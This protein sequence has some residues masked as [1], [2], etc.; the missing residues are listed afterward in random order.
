MIVHDVCYMVSEVLNLQP[1]APLS[2]SKSEEWPKWKRRFEQ[3]HQASGLVENDE[4]QQVSTL[5]YC[6][7][8]EAEEILDTTRISPQ[9]RVKYHKV[10]DEFDRYIKAKESVRANRLPR[11]KLPVIPQAPDKLPHDNYWGCG[12]D[13]QVQ[14]EIKFLNTVE[15]VDTV[16]N[17]GNSWVM[18]VAIG[19]K[20]TT[21]K[22]DT[23]AEVTVISEATGNSLDQSEPLQHPKVSLCGPDHSQLKVMGMLPLTIA[24]KEVYTTQPVYIVKN[25]K[26]NL[27]GFPAIKALKLLSHIESVDKNNLSEYPSLFSGLGTFTLEY[28]IQLKQDA[29]P[30]ALCTPRNIPLALRPKVQTELK[31]M[32]NLGVIS[33]V[34]EPTPWCAAMVVVPKASG[35]VRICVDVKPM[36][37]NV[38]REVHP[39]SKV[40]TTLAQLTGAAMFSKL[41]ANSGFWQIPL[42]EE[43]RLLTTFVTPY[44]RF[45]FNKL[46]FGI[47]SAPEVFQR[48]MNDIL[49]GLPGVLCHID[50]IL[51]FGTTPAEHDS[52]LQAV[53]ERI[54]SAGI[55]LNPDKCQFSQTQITFLGH[56]ID[57][58]GISPDPQKTS[59][60]LAMKSPSSVT[61][62]RRFMGMV[63]QM[64]KFSP[65]IA[66]FSKPLRELLSTKNSWTW[67]ASQAESFKKLKEEISSPRVLALYDPAAKTKVSADASAYGLGAVLLQQQQESQDQWRPIAFAS[68]ALSETELRYAQIEKEALAL[69]WALEKFSGYTLG[70]HIQL[71]SDHKPLIPLLG[72]KSLDLLPPRVL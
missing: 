8:E 9:D 11:R 10:I 66:H 24:Y 29:Q 31:H 38:L 59:A 55:T 50:D 61:E 44:G 64:S 19:D 12:T 26:N 33:R 40:D 20:V 7:G 39:M 22:V 32:E 68:R 23:G 46:P 47:S 43:S 49:S 48:Q 58:H 16:Q 56:V 27:L 54:K 30:F 4:R 21:F 6:L 45:C 62:L 28:K 5:L 15:F 36:N 17:M 18:Q 3:Y 72:Q 71:E 1:P 13:A 41:D 67:E 51:V 60:I 25:L 63:N 69:T 14:Q 34:T 70:K 42:A 65:T 35:A 53:L 52:R 2:F 37:E 57:H